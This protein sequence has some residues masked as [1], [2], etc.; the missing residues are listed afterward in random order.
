MARTSRPGIS[1]YR[2][3]CG[4]VR[5]K[6]LRLLYKEFD[7]TGYYVWSCLLDYGYGHNGYFF[8]MNNDED[9][10]LFAIEYCDKKL[11]LVKEIIAGCIRRGLFNKRVADAFG[12][13][14]CADM[15][16]T[17]LVA[18]A[19]RRN[20]GSVVYFTEEYLLIEIPETAANVKVVSRD[21]SITPPNNAIT[22]LNNSI[23]QPNNSQ[24]DEREET[25]K[26]LE[27][28]APAQ[29]FEKN[30]N[31][32]EKKPDSMN[33]CVV[34]FEKK[35]SNFPIEPQFIRQQAQK[36]FSHYKGLGWK[37]QGFPIQSWKG[38]A[39]EWIIKDLQKIK[40]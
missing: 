25:N 6:K 11:A 33:T 17:Y 5:N 18:T 10:E 31:E 34:Y 32:N 36:F 8:D 13:L 37:K 14:T 15:Q 9:L 35:M 23:F 2:M 27:R 19:D 4:H 3:D 22:P 16:E 40:S 39:D 21:G 29:L 1:F 12:I 26:I 28:V 38:I 30:N 7:A 20:K 24:R